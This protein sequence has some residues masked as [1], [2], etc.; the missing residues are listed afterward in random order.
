MD[1]RVTECE[2]SGPGWC[3]RHQCDKSHY[4]FEMC[5]RSETWFQLWETGNGVGQVAANEEAKRLSIPCIFRGSELRT[6]TCPT[7]LTHVSLK[8]FSCTRHAECTIAKRLDLVVCC[9]FCGDYSVSQ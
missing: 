5:R 3:A 7:C 2:C 9:A 6:E 8:V 1:E 4:R